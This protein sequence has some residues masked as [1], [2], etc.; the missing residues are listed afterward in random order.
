VVPAKRKS[1]YLSTKNQIREKVYPVIVD[2]GLKNV[3]LF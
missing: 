1:E 3:G 2:R